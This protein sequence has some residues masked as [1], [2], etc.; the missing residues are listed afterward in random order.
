MS[1]IDDSGI[2][3]IATRLQRLSERI[4]KDGFEVYKS[5]GIDFE[6]KFFPVVFSLYHKPGIGVLE[7]ATEIG[8]THPSTISLLKDLE[9]QGLVSSTKDK[10]DERKR[11]LALSE[12]GKE[13]VVRMVPV[14]EL[15]SLA[16]TELT[17]TQ[18][19]LMLAIKEVEDLLQQKSFFERAKEIHDRTGI[20]NSI[21]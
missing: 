21:K 3:A 19:N 9:S 5:Q 17:H 1:V 13:L 12:R 4:R 10:T 15:L 18:N 20:K 2:L 11:L 8:Y 14:W 16:A 7:L 6:P